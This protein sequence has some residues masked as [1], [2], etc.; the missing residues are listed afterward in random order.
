MEGLLGLVLNKEY[1]TSKSALKK[2]E[3]TNVHFF[4]K[5]IALEFTLVS[6]WHI[7]LK[8]N[9]RKLLFGPKWILEINVYTL[10]IQ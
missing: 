6:V 10:G 9:C 8:N 2:N 1:Q 5:E 3:K 7:F 4:P